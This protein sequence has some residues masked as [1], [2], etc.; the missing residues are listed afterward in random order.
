[1]RALQ[2]AGLSLRIVALLQKYQVALPIG[3]LPNSWGIGWNL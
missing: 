3:F 1:M 2:G